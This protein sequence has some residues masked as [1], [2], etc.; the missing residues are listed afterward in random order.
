MKGILIDSILSLS[1]AGFTN[2]ACSGSF[3]QCG[4]LNFAGDNCCISGY[5]CTFINEWYSECQLSTNDSNTS[6]KIVSDAI[7]TSDVVANSTS[8]ET[9][10]YPRGTGFTTHLSM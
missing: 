8:N 6:D 2:A 5:E 3:A 1:L 9:S 7:A 10:S 4:G